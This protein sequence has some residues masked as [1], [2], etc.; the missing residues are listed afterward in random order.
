MQTNKNKIAKIL[1]QAFFESEKKNNIREKYF[2]ALQEISGLM[3]KI[4]KLHVFLV[5][6]MFSWEEKEIFFSL[7]SLPKSVGLFLKLII[8]KRLLS[9]LNMIISHYETLL[10][11]AMGKTKVKVTVAHSYDISKS[12]EKLI[13]TKLEKLIKQKILLEYKVDPTLIGGFRL[14]TQEFYLDSSV[15]KALEDI[16]NSL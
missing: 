6:P 11:S 5:S 3:E 14:A 10:F 9:H 4:P 2:L 12:L 1:A 13:S 15:K 7:T 8:E 16:R